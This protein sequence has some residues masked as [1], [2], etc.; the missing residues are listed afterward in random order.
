[1]KLAHPGSLPRL[2]RA[3]AS[4]RRI[5]A[6][7]TR[8]GAVL[9]RARDQQGKTLAAAAEALRVPQTTIAAI[10]RDDYASL[11]EMAYVLSYWRNYALLLDVDIEPAIAEHKRGLS[12]D[13]VVS[14]A[15]R[16]TAN[17]VA[18]GGLTWGFALLS[19]LLLL[20][21]WHAQRPQ[22]FPP[23]PGAASAE[24]PLAERADPSSLLFALPQPIF[25]AKAEL[26]R[27]NAPAAGER[28]AL[29]SAQPPPSAQPQLALR[30]SPNEIT[31]AVGQDSWIEVRDAANVQLVHRLVGGGKRLL[32][33]GIPPF[34]VYI[35][36]A[37]GVAV[38]YQG[39]P[40]Q[41]AVKEGGLFARFNVGGR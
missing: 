13:A 6:E 30:A 22:S 19:M 8:P 36:N 26:E 9:R 10:E 41:F 23:A 29:Q 32:L 12:K 5:A 39:Q 18:R 1:M 2:R 25:R 35:G 14:R 16:A 38:E 24:A 21:A 7:R 40:V 15:P 11:P 3:R 31:L 17:A 4:A 34:S 20:A 33:K 27:R 37:G 28:L